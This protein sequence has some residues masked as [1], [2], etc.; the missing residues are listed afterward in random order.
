MSVTTAGT[1]LSR[2][3]PSPRVL[4][5][6]LAISAALNVFFVGGALWTRFHPPAERPPFEERYQRI[7][8]E[9]DL[10]AKQRAGFDRY[11]AA[12]RSR[13]DKMRDQVE[14]LMGAAW[15]EMAKPQP[16]AVQVMRLLDEAGDKRRAFQHE[17]TV[18]TLDMLSILSPEQRRKF[19]ALARER[20][21]AWRR[22][23]SASH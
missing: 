2:G 11:M 1:R 7:A 20:R 15:E 23:H 16:D 12:M 17:A 8:G 13:M 21:D 3:W 4:A 10:D 22:S 14:P 19:V 9:L 6:L 18:Q 5:A